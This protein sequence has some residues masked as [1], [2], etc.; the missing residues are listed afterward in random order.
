SCFRYLIY[1]VSAEEIRLVDIR[2]A[3]EAYLS[4]DKNAFRVNLIR[5]CHIL[6]IVSVGGP[7]AAKVIQ[8]GIYPMKKTEGG[9]AREVLGELQT[10]LATTPPP[11]LAK[12][13]GVAAGDR[14]RNYK[15]SLNS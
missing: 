2:S 3:G 5:D 14:V 9:Q 6:Y 7:A 12:V 13:M 8:A 1:Q 11:W 15:A 10:A 4:D